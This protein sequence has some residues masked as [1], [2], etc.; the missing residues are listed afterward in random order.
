MIFALNTQQTRSRHVAS[1]ITL[2]LGCIYIN[3]YVCMYVHNKGKQQCCSSATSLRVS[4]YSFWTCRDVCRTD[5]YKHRE[6]SAILK[7]TAEFPAFTWK[8]EPLDAVLTWIKPGVFLIAP[9]V[10][11]VEKTCLHCLF[12][13]DTSLFLLTLACLFCFVIAF[14]FI[15][16][17]FNLYILWIIWCTLVD[18]SRSSDGFGSACSSCPSLHLRLVCVSLYESY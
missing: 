17:I 3:I 15:F 8:A 16:T 1:D 6:P 12:A 18:V 4:A 5:L 13:L 14:V 11:E 7:L 2:S 10:E 9:Y